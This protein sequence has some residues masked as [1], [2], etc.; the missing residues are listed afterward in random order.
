MAARTGDGTGDGSDAVAP[1]R[2][3]TT[4]GEPVSGDGVP[5]GGQ[6]GPPSPTSFAHGLAAWR[7][8]LGKVRD[9]VRQELVRRQL[10]DHLPANRPLRV[11]DAGCGQGT[12]AIGLARLG[13]EVVGLDRSE[14]L[15][16]LAAEAA[17]AEGPAVGGRLRFVAGDLLALGGEHR[18]AFDLVCCHGV[19]MYL[20]SLDA[21][22]GAVLGAAR[23]GGLV[24]LLTRNRPA[25]AMRAGMSGDYA[26]ALAAFDARTYTNHLGVEAVRADEPAEVRAAFAASG[27]DVVAW[28]GVR[29]FT[30]HLPAE[31]PPPEG[32][33]ALLAAEAE[34]GRRDPYRALTALTHT[35]ARAGS[36]PVSPAA[37]RARSR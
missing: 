3:R 21:T 23:P 4:G 31:A 22:V 30:D 19:A 36:V 37:G 20:P 10:A 13:H 16:G 14:E 29:L 6:T 26:G 15:L 34:A 2:S 5:A 24:S 8:G 28:Y 27:A 17:R 33:E 9:L 25:I 18:G 1:V 11:L 7:D 35:L 32:I 12:Q